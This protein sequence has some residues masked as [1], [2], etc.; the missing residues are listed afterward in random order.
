MSLTTLL[1][2][3]A[4]AAA[5]RFKL[6]PEEV[7]ADREV[8]LEAEVARLQCSLKIARRDLDEVVDQRDALRAELHRTWARHEEAHRARLLADRA[9]MMA[10]MAQHHQYHLSPAHA[11]QQQAQAQLAGM[12]HAQYAQ[13]AQ[14]L[15][16]GL[17][18]LG[19]FHDCTCVP[20]RADMLRGSAWPALEARLAL[21]DALAA[22]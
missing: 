2:A 21:D 1:L 3:F 19:Q 16:Q 15:A 10:Q 13:Q 7:K 8:E 18:Q 14:G 9:Q 5:A 22:Q 11:Q 17:G 4:P 12:Q 20:A 6:K